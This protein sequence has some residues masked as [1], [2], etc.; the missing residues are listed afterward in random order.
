MILSSI[1]ASNERPELS[2]VIDSTEL[3]IV[4]IGKTGTGKSATGNTILGGD[5]HFKSKVGGA[6]ITNKCKLA[7]ITRFGRKLVVVD[8]P[9]LF[10]TEMPNEHVTKEIVK[11]IGMTAPGPHAFLLTVSVAGRFTKEEQDTVKHF[12]DHF[13]D[14]MYNYLMVI[15]T[16]ADDLEGE[17]V[18]I[19]DYVRNCP[20]SLKEILNLCDHR[21]IPFNNKLDGYRQEQQVKKFISSVDDVVHKN[22]G[23]CYSN[24]MYEEA[25]KTLRRREDELKRKLKEEERRKV[26]TLRYQLQ[27]EFD[28][29][30]ELVNKKNE[31]LVLQIR[32]VEMKTHLAEMREAESREQIAALESNLKKCKQQEQN[33]EQEMLEMRLYDMER[34][35]AAEMQIKANKENYVAQVAQLKKQMEDNERRAKQEMVNMKRENERIVHGIKQDYRRQ[36]QAPA[37]RD[38]SRRECEK[39]EGVFSK[40]WSGIKGFLGKVKNFF[41]S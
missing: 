3:R 8:T 19:K 34:K 36:Q 14:G 13:G 30:I 20:Q 31:R 21:Y 4:I 39:E 32:E 6:S 24:E 2:G 12:V 40:I 10:D 11:C 22:G 16:R 35:H 26:E 41:F 7:W 5:R 1:V 28:K 17:N 9:G 27:I 18:D 23:I 25:E 29:K 38:N 33:R 37:L 15:F